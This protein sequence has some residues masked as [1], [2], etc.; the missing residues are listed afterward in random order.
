MALDTLKTSM[1]TEV[2]GMLKNFLDGLK[3]STTLLEVVDPTNKVTDANFDKGGA[4]SDKVPLSSGRSGNGI[5]AHVEPPITYGGPVPSTHLNHVGPPPKLVKNEDFS[6]WVYHLKRHLNHSSTNLWRI[7]EQGFSPHDP[8]N[9]TPREAADHQ[10]NES[11]LF[12]IQDA[13]HPKILHMYDLS[14]WPRKHGNMFFP[15]TRE[16]QAFNAPTMK[17]CK[18][19]PMSLR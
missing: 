11:A 18:M 4:T 9:F 6:P 1:T 10:F 5:F 16:A 13:T 7:I 3:L 14:L 15:Y 17:W 12:I 19:K 2:K 8:S